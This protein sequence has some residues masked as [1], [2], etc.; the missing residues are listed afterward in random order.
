MKKMFFVFVYLFSFHFIPKESILITYT[1]WLHP[2]ML[3]AE[4]IISRYR[5]P[6][7]FT[8]MRVAGLGQAVWGPLAWT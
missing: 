6:K 7:L 3:S 4:L 1:A 5:R 2:L 8:G